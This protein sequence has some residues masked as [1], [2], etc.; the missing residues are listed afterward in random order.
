MKFFE[1]D[2]HNLD[3]EWTNQP[4]LYW[5]SAENLAHARAAYERAKTE[6]KVVEAELD[7]EIRTN[8][9]AHG[10]EKITEPAIKNTINL[11]PKYRKAVDDEILKMHIKDLYEAEI[12]T[13]DNRKKA[14]EN[15]VQLHL[16]NYYS[17]PKLPNKEGEVMK[18]AERD[19]GFRTKR[20]TDED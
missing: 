12:Y 7:K 16:A 9:A 19:H 13:L 5:K 15:L 20:R 4:A 14:L 8:P 1:L 6:T 10:L 2:K 17:S 11:N 3:E 18:R